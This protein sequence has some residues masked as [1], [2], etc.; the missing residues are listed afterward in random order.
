MIKIIEGFEKA[1]RG[2]YSNLDM[3]IH[4]YIYVYTHTVYIPGYDFLIY[5][6]DI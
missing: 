1:P 5:N 6:I 2:N 4:I 3:C